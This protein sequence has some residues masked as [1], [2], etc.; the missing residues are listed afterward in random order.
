[1]K[2]RAKNAEVLC[3]STK[4]RQCTRQVSGNTLQQVEKFKYL[5]WYLRVTEGG[6]RRLIHG[7]INLRKF[8]RSVVTKLELS[9]TAKLPVFKSVVVPI[10]TYGRESCV[11]TERILTQVQAPKMGFCE[12]STV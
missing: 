8:Y 1:M 6:A 11:M 12:E 2:I 5:G 10:L 9:N 7:K 3:L 4:P